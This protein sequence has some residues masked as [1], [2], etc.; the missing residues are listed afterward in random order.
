[1]KHFKDFGLKPNVNTFKGE[2]IKIERI[3]NR[4]I[5]VYAFEITPSKFK[6]ELL[7]MQI[8]VANEF[9]VLFTGSKVLID[10]IKRVPKENFPFATTI[11]KEHE[12][13][14]FS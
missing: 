13:F 2:K 10:T 11:I 5:I 3:I 4:E 9:R 1:M 6:D 8:K 12:Y 14:E 7:S